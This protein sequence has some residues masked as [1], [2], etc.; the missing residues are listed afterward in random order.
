MF[1]IDNNLDINIDKIYCISFLYFDLNIVDKHIYSAFH[2]DSNM[3]SIYKVD[4][5][6]HVTCS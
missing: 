6:F 1:N 2:L 3:R 4:S 5:S